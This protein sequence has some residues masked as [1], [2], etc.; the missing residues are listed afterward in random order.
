[1]SDDATNARESAARRYDEAAAE[2]EA[3]VHHL[4][5]AAQHFRDAEVPRGCAHAFAAYGH[6]LITQRLVDENAILH[7]A[8]AQR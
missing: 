7:A 6:L 3:A 8:R 2:L 4:R 5:G 1:M